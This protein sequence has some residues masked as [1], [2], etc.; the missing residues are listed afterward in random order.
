MPGVVLSPRGVTSGK[1]ASSELV[2]EC[3]KNNCLVLQK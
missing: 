1:K 3:S 2:D